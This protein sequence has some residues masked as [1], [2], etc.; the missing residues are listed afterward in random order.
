MQQEYRRLPKGDAGIEKNK[1]RCNNDQ[2]AA[3]AVF[4][5]Q[6]D[7]RDEGIRTDIIFWKRN[8]GGSD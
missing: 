2:E 6:H 3:Q 7:T 5:Q 8:T 1:Q 4:D